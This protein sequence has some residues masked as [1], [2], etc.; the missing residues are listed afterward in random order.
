MAGTKIDTVHHRAWVCNHAE[1]VELRTRIAG[2]GLVDEAAAAD[3]SSAF[4]T[5]GLRP[6]PAETVRS[7]GQ[8]QVLKFERGG[9]Q[10]QDKR[11]WGMQGHIYYDGS[12]YRDPEPELS[13]ATFCVVEVDDSGAVQA[14]LQGT[15]TQGMPPSSQ[16]GE[17][18]G[19]AAAVQLLHGPSSI[20]GDCKSVVCAGNLPSRVATHRKRMHVGA[21][22]LA[23]ASGNNVALLVVC[24]LLFG[25][26]VCSLLFVILCVVRWVVYC[27]LFVVCSLLSVRC[28]CCV[29]CVVRYVLRVVCCVSCV[30]CGLL[31]FAC[32]VLYAVC[33]VRC[34]VCCVC[35]VWCVVRC[36]LFVCCVCCVLAVVCM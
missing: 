16:S 3:P 26:V 19:R 5:R 9:C 4:L 31:C 24:C 7:L 8:E 25:V 12:C 32:C 1:A 14:R 21:R 22:R 33:C 11:L 35:C 2:Q 29:L 10:I 20:H 18:C 34:V 23:D 36:L 17:H 27:L 28:V 6:H 30:V 15:V 13:R